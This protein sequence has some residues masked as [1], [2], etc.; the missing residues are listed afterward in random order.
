MQGRWLIIGL[1]ASVALNLFLLGT[2][3]GVVALG[4]RMAQ[5][6]RPRPGAF[7][8]ATRELPP[9]PRMAMRAM[10][11]QAW[12]QQ[13][14]AARQSLALRIDAWTAL[15]APIPDVAAIKQKLEQSRG[16]DTASRTKVEE[17]VVNYAAALPADQRAKF[18][19]GM[20]VALQPQSPKPQP[21]AAR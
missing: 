14:P 11:Q 16:I 12:S 15:A 1:I 18:A 6:G 8:R 3:A 7:V 13:A 10:L 21:T 5:E 2:A 19:Q 9:E 4:M 20:R 17:A